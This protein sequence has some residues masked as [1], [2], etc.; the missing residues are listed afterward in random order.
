MVKYVYM[1]GEEIAYLL[2]N[3]AYKPDVMGRN[4]AKIGTFGKKFGF[5]SC[6]HWVNKNRLPVYA[7][8]LAIGAIKHRENEE[9]KEYNNVIVKELIDDMGKLWWKTRIIGNNRLD[10]TKLIVKFINELKQELNTNE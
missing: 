1:D 2:K 9:L 3:A 8:R 5:K 6:H 4:K 10:V 7:Y